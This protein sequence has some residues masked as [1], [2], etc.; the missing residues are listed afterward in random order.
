MEEKRSEERG[1]LEID[2]WTNDIY[3]TSLKSEIL[4]NLCTEIGV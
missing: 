1:G 3:Y 2:N 4:S